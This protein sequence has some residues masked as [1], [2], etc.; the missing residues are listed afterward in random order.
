MLFFTSICAN[1]SAKAKVL[2]ES[3][4]DH[5]PRDVFVVG[6]NERTIYPSLKTSEIDEIILVSELNIPKFKS[7]IFKYDNLEASTAT[8]GYYFEELM[9]R[10]PKQN[11]FV[12][13]D[14][15]ILVTGEFKDLKKILKT[16]DIVLT[17]H[18][19]KA[20]SKKKAIV[21]KE[22]SSLKHGVYNL[23][24]LALNRSQT[25]LSFLDWYTDR[26][27]EFCFNDM[28]NGLFTDQK[29]VDLAPCFFD[30]LVYK[31]PGF[32]LA[33]WNLSQ[34]S[35]NKDGSGRYFVDNYPLVF[36]HFSGWDS[37]SNYVATVE[38]RHKKNLLIAELRNKYKAKLRMYNQEEVKNL[39]WSYDYYNNGAK[40]GV[41]DRFIFRLNE[42][43][44]KN[45][46]DPFSSE[47]SSS[48]IKVVRNYFVLAVAALNYLFHSFYKTKKGYSSKAYFLNN[49]NDKF[50]L[51]ASAYRKGGFKFLQRKLISKLNY[52]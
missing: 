45:I 29:W 46:V 2:A 6:L 31:N 17:P 36:V 33:P 44:Q 18:L 7:F 42:R 19:L 20:E 15:D 40:I 32:N 11:Q 35:I 26:L 8:K 51:I 4:K 22:I 49:L 25:S 24:F 52:R 5:N 30:V 37:G 10:Y 13:L 1:Y 50:R 12:Y 3:L 39:P 41:K 34:R 27:S 23:G 21:D 43:M 38:Y 47:M 14:P 9:R 28:E 48:F 16:S